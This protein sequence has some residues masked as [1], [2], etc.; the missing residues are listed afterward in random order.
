L[1]FHLQGIDGPDKYW[2]NLEAVF[3]KHNVIR[4]Q[5]IENHLM[6]LRPNDFPCIDLFV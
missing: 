3:G 2:E 1:W 4:A 5:E 6:T